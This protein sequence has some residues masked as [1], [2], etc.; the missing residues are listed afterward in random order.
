MGYGDRICLGTMTSTYIA[1][2]I[3]DSLSGPSSPTYLPPAKKKPCRATLSSATVGLVRCSARALVFCACAEDEAGG[4]SRATSS[5]TRGFMS[6][7][8]Q[9][10]SRA[11]T[12]ECQEPL[13]R[14]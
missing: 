13:R 8:R 1:P 4:A 12:G 7:L 11:V 14:T 3:V 2:P 9:A 6:Y 5:A 10:V